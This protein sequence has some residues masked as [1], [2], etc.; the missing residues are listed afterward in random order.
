M[1]KTQS[2]TLIALPK[3]RSDGRERIFGLAGVYYWADN[4]ID[5]EPTGLTKEVYLAEKRKQALVVRSKPFTMLA[6]LHLSEIPLVGAAA[7]RHK[8]RRGGN[9]H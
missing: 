5:D 4:M 1:L 6:K 7:F 8:E 9:S 2:T 3:F